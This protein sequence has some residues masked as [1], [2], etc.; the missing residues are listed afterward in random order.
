M[1]GLIWL[2]EPVCVCETEKGPVESE[3]VVRKTESVSISCLRI[4]RF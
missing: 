3:P 1:L 4:L 2:R